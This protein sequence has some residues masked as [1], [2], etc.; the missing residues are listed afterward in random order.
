[1]IPF[2]MP[3]TVKLKAEGIP[4]FAAKVGLSDGN[5]ALRIVEKISN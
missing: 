2:D 1:V 5:Y 3:E 4:V